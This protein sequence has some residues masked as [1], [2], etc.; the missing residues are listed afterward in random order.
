VSDDNRPLRVLYSFPDALGKYAI[1]CVA[2]HQIAGLARR[3]HQVHVFC[4]SLAWPDPGAHRLVR[5]LSLGGRRIPHRVL[6]WER[7]HRYHDR[8]VA[9][10]LRRL[11]GRIDVV[12]LWPRATL[13]TAAAAR[14]RGARTVREA[15]N[16][17]TAV[18]YERAAEETAALG[19]LPAKGHTHYSGDASL[20]RELA[21]YD[22][23]DVVAAQ[24]EYARQTFLDQGVPADRV[25]MHPNGFDPARFPAPDDIASR[26]QDGLRAVFVGTC[27]P[28]KGLHYALEAW[29]ESGAAERGTFRVCGAFYPGYADALGARLRHPSVRLE[30]WVDEPGRILRESDVFLYPSVEEGGALVAFEAMA[31]GCA[32]VVSDATGAR[33][34][35]GREGLV[36][37]ARDVATLTE[38][39]RTLDRDRELLERLRR[40]AVAARPR[41]TWD[42]AAGEL[43]ALYRGVLAETPARYTP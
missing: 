4:T 28:R 34:E 42:V 20:R 32:L 35:H 22:A 10:A 1:G 11:S 18:A 27:E 43:E 16:C 41:L 3:G 38:H 30:G 2:W 24:T 25:A 7:A 31:S 13:R 37:T 19:L 23:V 36:H 21:E 29:I 40:N 39:L 33:C 5:T 26:P 6:G 8:V 9:G 12:H 17:H 14:E 15:P